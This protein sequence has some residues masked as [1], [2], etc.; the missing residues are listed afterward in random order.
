MQ[1]TSG[2]PEGRRRNNAMMVYKK[3]VLRQYIYNGMLW[4][5][6]DAEE[7]A[8]FEL[9]ID[10]LYVGIIAVVGDK[11]TED[12]SGWPMVHFVVSGVS[13]RSRSLAHIL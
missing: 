9:F 8:S 10:L 7:V 4:R 1:L 13:P 11:A 12:P 5:A 6:E 2:K 3:P